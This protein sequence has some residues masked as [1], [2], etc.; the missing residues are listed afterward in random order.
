MLLLSLLL[1]PILAIFLIAIEDSDEN[2]KYGPKLFNFQKYF[3][4]YSLIKA[5]KVMALGCVTINFFISLFIFIMFDFSS[6]QFQFVQEP[7]NINEYNFYLGLD[8]ISIYFVLLTTIIMPITLISNWNSISKDIKWYLIIM[9]LLETLLLA[10]FMVLD[11]FLFYIFFESILP[12]ATW[13]G[14]SYIWF[15]YLVTLVIVSWDGSYIGAMKQINKFRL[16]Y[17]KRQKPEFKLDPNFVTG[18]ADAEGSF[19]VTVSRDPDNKIGWRVKSAFEIGLHSK[20][21]AILELIQNYF[22]KIGTISLQNKDVVRFR[23][24]SQEDL[25]TI[26]DHFDN[27]PLLTK[28]LADYMLFKDILGLMKNKEH[29]TLDGLKKILAIKSVLNLGLSDELKSAFPDIV[30]VPRPT[31][32]PPKV[33]NSQWLAGL[34]SGDG[35]FFVSIFKSPTKLGEAVRLM[36]TI[37]QHNRDEQL[38][39]NLVNYLGFGRYVARNNAE[40]GE[41]L[42]TDLKSITNKVIPLFNKYPIVGIKSQDFQDFKQV[43]L[44]MENKEHLTLKGLK[45]IREIKAGMN[46]GR[47]S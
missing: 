15:P 3:G 14:K 26:I 46:K 9:L 2:Y 11:I 1:L 28:K 36:F 31:V 18:F 44:L 21:I 5:Q 16:Y 47:V 25:M 33:F 43:A 38:M 12:P 6:N 34:V 23:V 22:N 40:H 32:Q 10:V 8:G 30:A 29:L 41:F 37:T 42:V 24:S 19:T 35:C 4:E 39:K 17:T 20:D 13:S 45:K 27:Y 7:H